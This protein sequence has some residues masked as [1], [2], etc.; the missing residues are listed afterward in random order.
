MSDES[1]N[2]PDALPLQVVLIG[3]ALNLGVI[4]VVLARFP[5]I[6]GAE[7]RIWVLLDIAV[8]LIYGLVAY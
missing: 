2:R 8:P 4:A 7:R 5:A 6:F 1:P 3:A